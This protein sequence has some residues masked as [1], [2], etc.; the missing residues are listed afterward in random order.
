MQRAALD[1]ADVQHIDARETAFVA[2]VEHPV[3]TGRES[4]GKHDG[5]RFGQILQVG[6]IVVHHRQTLLAVVLRPG[7]GNKDHTA[8]EIA[9]LAGDP[10]VNRIGHLMRHAAPAIDGAAELQTALPAAVEQFLAREDVIDAEL[11]VDAV[12]A[13]IDR[14]GDQRLRVDRLPVGIFHRRVKIADGRDIGAGRDFAEKARAGQ[15]F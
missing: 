4:R 6:P 14:P 13:D 7:F 3:A 9:A 8:V 11:Y 12:A 1:G 10:A 5:A 2:G 15:V